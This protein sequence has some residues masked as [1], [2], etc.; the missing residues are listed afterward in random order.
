MMKQRN[1][2]TL[3]EL[4]VVITIIGIL[5]GLLLPAVQQARESG[6]QTECK[7]NL[8]QLVTALASYES[9]IGHFPPGREGCDGWNSDICANVPGRDRPG[10]SGFVH[11][12]PHLEQLALYELFEPSFKDG[13]IAPA[14]PSDQDDGTTANWFSYEVSVGIQRRPDFISCPSDDSAPVYPFN[15]RN[16]ATGSYAFVQGSQ[17]PTYGIDAKKVKCYNNGPFLYVRTVKQRDIKDGMSNTIFIGETVEADTRESAN[18]WLIGSRHLHSM[19]STDNPLNTQ[20]GEGVWV[21]DSGGSP[22]YGY[23]AN[24]A[25]ASRHP[26]GCNFAFGD[27]HVVFLNEN[28]DLFTYRALSTIAGGEIASPPSD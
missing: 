11:L 18:I 10:T 26:A 6:R 27:G 28:I 25:F 9:D 23:K 8:K 21:K 19:R 22:L 13:A 5:V 3:V 1:A 14:Q 15:S 7:N 16:Y 4:L 24:G 2:F 20:P 12:L 17:G